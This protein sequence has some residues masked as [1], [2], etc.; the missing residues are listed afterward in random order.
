LVNCARV[1]SVSKNVA[2]AFGGDHADFQFLKSI[3]DDKIT[4]YK[5]E[6]NDFDAEMS[7]NALFNWLTVVMYHRRCKFDPIYNTIIV[8]GT[9]TS[10]TD[11]TPFLSVLNLRGVAY[12]TKYVATGIGA[13]LIRQTMEN[14]F[15][16]ANGGGANKENVR[17]TRAEA[18]QLMH[19]CVEVAQYRDCLASP[20]F[21]IVTVCPGE[22]V[23]RVPVAAPAV[24]KWKEMAEFTIGYS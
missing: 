10:H 8:A 23:Q 7:A 16:A 4:T 20:K 18:I 24:G 15:R 12:S 2:I 6:M 17:M 21:E 9:R 13:M 3:V 1:L 11:P 22:G 19:T 5:A 14:E